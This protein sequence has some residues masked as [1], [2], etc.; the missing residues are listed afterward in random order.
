MGFLHADRTRRG[1]DPWLTHKQ[2]LF[3]FGA[4]AGL[5]GI[6]LNLPW[7]INIGIAVLAVGIVLRFIKRRPAS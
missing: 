3:V 5:I 7:L 2:I 6:M 1:P 4:V